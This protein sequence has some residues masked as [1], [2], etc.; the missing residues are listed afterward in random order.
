MWRART[1]GVGH[2]GSDIRWIGGGAWGI[3]II[4]FW[5]QLRCARLLC[6]EFF[7]LTTEIA[8][9]HVPPTI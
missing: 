5:L 9:F 7:F 8:G 2:R 3:I 1:P 4:A 6:L